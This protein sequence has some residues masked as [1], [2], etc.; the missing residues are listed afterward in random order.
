MRRNRPHPSFAI[1]FLC[2]LSLVSAAQGAPELSAEQRAKVDSLSALMLPLGKDPQV[3]A[4][5]KAQNARL[6]EVLAGMDEAKW[7][8]LTVESPELLAV[9]KSELAAYL[10]GRVHHTV[11]E[12][13]INDAE[14][15]KVVLFAKTSNWKHKGKAKHDRPMLGKP[16]TGP[17]E[18][19]E[20]T[21]QMQ[22]QVSFPVLDGD[23][24]IGSVVL[25]FWL[26]KL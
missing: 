10:R 18:L 6:P 22:V 25:G 11:I 4:A 21:G 2:A 5:V 19:D 9:S 12:L 13:F 3:V 8:S 17:L 7:K 24:P 15:R 20:S 1:G 14:G 16:W 23:K 26:P